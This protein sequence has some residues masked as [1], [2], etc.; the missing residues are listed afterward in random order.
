[1]HCKEKYEIYQQEEKKTPI[2]EIEKLKKL[3]EDFLFQADITLNS[4]K[5][6]YKGLKNF[7]TWAKNTFESNIPLARKTIIQYKNLLTNI[8]IKPHTQAIYLVSIR[9]FFHWTESLLI[10]PNIAKNIKGIKKLTKQHH[11]N[12]LSKEEISKLIKSFP[13]KTIIE[14]RDHALLNLLIFTGMRIGETTTIK[15]NDIEKINE[16]KYIIW[17]RG[18]GR[19]GKDN[20]VILVDEIINKVQSYIKERL[21]DERTTGDNYLFVSHGPRKK[22]NEQITTDSIGR[23]VNNRMKKAEVKNKHIS[24]HSLRHSFGVA[25][26]QAGVSLHELQIAMRHASS[27]TTQVY[28]G[29]IEKIKRKEADPETRVKNFFFSKEDSD[30]K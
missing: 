2:I 24:P 5:T 3:M 19:S 25:A 15:I 23:I 11:K 26:I 29:D 7:L 20:F 22:E 17:I 14:K 16:T 28:L 8:N 27:T 12:P 18:K 1:M 30:K 4:K 10:F 13:E 21:K 6:Y 9:Q